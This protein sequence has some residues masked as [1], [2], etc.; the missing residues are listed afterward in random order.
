MQLIKR[1]DKDFQKKLEPLLK[2]SAFSSDIDR[3]VSEILGRVRREGDAAL[4]AFALQ[5]DHA[6]LNPQEFRV[7]DGEC[8]EAAKS[9]DAAMR[10][11]VDCAVDQIQDFAHRSLPVNWSC[12]PRA[13]VTLGEQFSPLERVGCYVPG[14]TAPLI[15][16][17]VHTVAIAAAA[18]VREIVVVT[19]P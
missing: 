7:S 4:S 6:A 3:S 1:N 9:V 15:S 11:A 14:G 10:A 12:T 16:T 19:P 5:F 18:G 13:G 8:R 17:V 2:R